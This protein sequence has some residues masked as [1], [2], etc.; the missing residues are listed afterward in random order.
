MAS[1]LMTALSYDA[2]RGGGSVRLAYELANG[3]VSRGHQVSVVCQDIHG[4]REHEIVQGVTVLRYRLPAAAG[5][6]FRRHKEHI[7]AAAQVTSKYLRERPQV[8]N[9]HSLFQYVAVM[10]ECGG[11][12]HFCYTIHSPFSEEVRLTWGA[13]GVAGRIKRLLGL[14]IIRRLELES[15]NGSEALIALSNY[16]RALIGQLY[17]AGFSE[18]IAVIPGW[19]DIRRF[20]PMAAREVTTARRELGWPTDRRVFFVLRRLEARMGLDNLL[21]AMYLVRERGYHVHTFIGGA[22]SRL[23]HL[24][25]LR[26]NLG[27]EHDVTFMG[28]VPRDKLPLAY[29]ACDASIVPTSHLECFGI[30]VLEALAC[31]RPVLVTPVGA[32]PEVMKH[33]EPAWVALGREPSALADLLCVYLDGR[34]PDH[35]PDVL[36]G[37][38]SERFSFERALEMYE[39]ILLSRG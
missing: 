38:L 6:P 29:A 31:G 15:L 21:R 39:R 32:L 27:L 3:L 33:F 23:R 7:L 28:F 4:H 16:T 11:S 37:I 30:I 5:I 13:Q 2:D 19:T 26:Q 25:L 24:L 10:R 8:V 20:R 34:L 22:G 9:G 17:G 35:R 12:A 1:I 18:R 14:P 36:R